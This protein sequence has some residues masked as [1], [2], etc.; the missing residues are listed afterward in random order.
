MMWSS[1]DGSRGPA[2]A[3]RRV[4]AEPLVRQERNLNAVGVGEPGE[5]RE[6]VVGDEGDAEPLVSWVPIAALQRKELCLA[7]RSA[8]R[9]RAEHRQQAVRSG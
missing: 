9:R 4:V 3:F 1:R 8:V 7:V 6:G 2:S 5:G